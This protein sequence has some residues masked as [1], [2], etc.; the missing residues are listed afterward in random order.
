MSTATLSTATQ[1]KHTALYAAHVQLGAKMVPF[2]GWSMPVSYQGVLAEHK[3]VRNHVGMFDV[4]H[5]GQIWV[6]GPGALDLIQYAT[7]NDLSKLR[8]GRAQYGMLPNDRG[9][10]IDDLYIYRIEDTTYL[11]VANASNTENV[12]QHLLNLAQ[13]HMA[14]VKDVSNRYA[15]IALQGPEA[16]HTLSH[17][18]LDVSKKI[19]NDVWEDTLLGIQVRIARTGYTGEDGFEL[20]VSPEEVSSL[21]ERFLAQGVVPCG[22]GARDTLRLEMGYPLYGHEF[23]EG[24]N[25]LAT[26][27]KWAIKTHKDFY[28]KAALLSGGLD[29]QLVGLRLKE[30][31]IP[32]EGYRV[33]SEQEAIGTITSGSLSPSLGVGIALAYIDTTY[34]QPG[35]HVL[36]EVRN[37]HVSAEVTQVPFVTPETPQGAS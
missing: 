25:P 35:T 10:L 4:S 8:V 12:T 5:M 2:G 21:W 3:S 31:G 28:G 32:R 33:F 22:L 19:K 20:F 36:I 26:H 7:T 27:M 23:S 17:L 14:T 16:G 24:L 29:R 6:S 37:Q 1:L 18:G 34:A 11:V 9:G 30:K 15:L 13:N